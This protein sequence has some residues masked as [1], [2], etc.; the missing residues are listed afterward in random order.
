MVPAVGAFPGKNASQFGERHC[1]LASEFATKSRMVVV[2]V[3][4]HQGSPL[5]SLQPVGNAGSDEQKS[6]IVM[7]G[8]ES[9]AKT[10]VSH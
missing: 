10:H 2:V 3:L 6:F 4:A 8:K 1:Q 9:V 7:D 5:K